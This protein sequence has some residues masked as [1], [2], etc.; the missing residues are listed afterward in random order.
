MKALGIY[1]SPRKGGNTDQLLDK[2][3]EGAKS[4]GAETSSVYARDLDM[5]G[6][7]ECG[8]CDKTGKCVVKDDM[9]DVYP[10]L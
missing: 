8:G 10:L 3:L 9:Q 1:G 5:S 2:V 7:I 6:C 4:G